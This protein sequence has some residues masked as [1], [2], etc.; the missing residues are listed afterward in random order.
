M[1]CPHCGAEDQGGKFC[2]QC[3]GPLT[4]DGDRAHVDETHD[5][6]DRDPYDMETNRTDYEEDPLQNDRHRFSNT[7]EED[8][9]WDNARW[10]GMDNN[11]VLLIGAGILVITAALNTTGVGDSF[12]GSLIGL[13]IALGISTLIFNY[14][15]R[16]SSA[17]SGLILTDSIR[18]RFTTLMVL[19]TMAVNLMST[20]LGIIF[21]NFGWLFAI[22]LS[23]LW[24]VKMKDAVLIILEPVRSANSVKEH[25]ATRYRKRYIT[26]VLILTGIGIAIGLIIFFAAYSYFQELFQEFM[27]HNT[28]YF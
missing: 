1:Y 10:L 15:Y 6:Y 4:S 19:A 2:S 28:N 16:R 25:F 9:D 24:W 27:I 11:V 13:L 18:K 26:F 22:A 8:V 20:L 7:P 3:G 14:I 23:I 12:F 5:E 17:D 21:R